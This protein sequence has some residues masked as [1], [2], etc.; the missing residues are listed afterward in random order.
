[1]ISGYSEDYFRY[2]CSFCFKDDYINR[3]S[4][5]LRTLMATEF[6]YSIPMDSN[7]NVDGINMR[8]DFP[9]E[10]LPRNIA[11][12]LEVMVSMTIR[13]DQT[14]LTSDSQDT[15]L[16][17]FLMISNIGL[18][19]STDDNFNQSYVETRIRMLLSRDYRPDGLGNFFYIEDCVEDL[20]NVDI[21]TQMSWYLNYYD[22][23]NISKERI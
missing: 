6:F 23:N 13:C 21:G 22:E 19:N 9:Q 8:A 7:R 15:T 2:L 4:M 10:M 1:M 16:W 3:Y 20:R 5:L 17:F 18:V 12:L 11:T 14:I